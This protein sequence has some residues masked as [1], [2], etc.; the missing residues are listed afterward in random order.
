MEGN[1]KKILLIYS[2]AVTALVVCLFI[3]IAM[4]SNRNE[5]SSYTGEENSNRQ[6]VLNEDLVFSGEIENLKDVKYYYGRM[7]FQNNKTIA[8]IMINNETQA[9]KVEART[10][11]VELLNKQG[12]VVATSEAQMDEILG[13]N[14]QVELTAEFDLKEP[15]I[16]YDIHITAKDGKANTEEKLT[17]SE[18]TKTEEKVEEA[19]V[20]PTPTDED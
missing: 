10:V 4:I 14:G 17:S 9:E 20:A 16:I 8:Y 11:V 18:E 15:Q 3:A 12:Q 7:L 6:I 5:T 19:T 2:I 13:A 1:S